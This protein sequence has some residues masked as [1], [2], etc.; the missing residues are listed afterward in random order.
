MRS[1]AEGGKI[2]YE[3]VGK[4][5]VKRMTDKA[6]RLHFENPAMNDAWVPLSVIAV[7]SMDDLAK[8]Q[9]TAHC[10]IRE[11]FVAKNL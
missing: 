2:E 4:A 7:K 1:D 5:H 9:A 3:D 8:Y 10:R 11:W 6:V